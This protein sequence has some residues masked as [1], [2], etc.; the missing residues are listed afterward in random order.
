MA[1]PDP[2]APATI[3]NAD[4]A[5]LF[6]NMTNM[7]NTITALQNQLN[8]RPAQP[9][10]A[11]AP[12]VNLTQGQ[13]QQIL[14]TVQQ[15]PARPFVPT[16][17]QV[18]TL[19]ER[20]AGTIGLQ[21]EIELKDYGGNPNSEDPRG[22]NDPA[23]YDGTKADAKPFLQRLKTHFSFLPNRFR[24]AK[25][26]I[27]YA[28]QLMTASDATRTWA[29]AV[30]AART[31]NVD[32]QYWYYD[33]EDFEK[34]FLLIFGHVNDEEHAVNHIRIFS[35]GKA[36]YQAWLIEFEELAIRSRLP[37]VVLLLFFKQHLNSR[38]RMR[39][40][41]KH[42]V[43]TDYVGWKKAAAEVDQQNQEIREY[44]ALFGPDD[45]RPSRSNFYPPSNNQAPRERSPHVKPMDLSVLQHDEINAFQQ[46]RDKKH[47]K[48]KD[49]KSKGKEREREHKP[50]DR[51]DRP[52]KR[53]HVKGKF[54]SPKRPLPNTNTS[55]PSLSAFDPA[56][57]I[58]FRCGQK[59]HVMKNCVTRIHAIGEIPLDDRS[60]DDEDTPTQDDSDSSES[61]DDTNQEDDS[62]TSSSSSSTGN[63][64]EKDF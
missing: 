16:T 25:D 62:A 7:G 14:T 2:N 1:T 10:P 26:R 51:K 38:I 48:S 60:T 44:N 57:A 3:T 12:T 53:E 49:R 58:C 41:N 54:P 22:I 31:N 28:C 36:S 15:R 40:F 42:P 23:K 34:A 50:K 19:K 13:L 24:L 17:D 4:L 35:Q 64:Q 8:A 43:P 39:I 29:T 32:N 45:G 6:N 52:S 5:T 46:R 37:D 30:S 11:P 20:L 59:G 55:G 9:A 33:Y 63:S 61:E 21:D 56:T 27:L 18:K 47:K